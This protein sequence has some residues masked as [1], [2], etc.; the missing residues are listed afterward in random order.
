MIIHVIRVC[1][2]LFFTDLQVQRLSAVGGVG[3]EAHA[4]RYLKFML[5]DEV[6]VKY[7]WKGR[8]KLPFE[9][10]NIMAIIYDKVILGSVS[11]QDL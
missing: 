5:G 4:R 1:V 6:A 8:D 9:N 10:T 11:S 2:L 3:V 7:N